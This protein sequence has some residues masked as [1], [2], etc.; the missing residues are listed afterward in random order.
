MIMVASGAAQDHLAAAAEPAIERAVDEA[1]RHWRSMI[2]ASST[3]LA[4]A[5]SRPCTTCR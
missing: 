2:M 5:G 3:Q 4:S 1:C